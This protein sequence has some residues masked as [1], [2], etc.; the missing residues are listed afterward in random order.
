MFHSLRGIVTPVAPQRAV[1]STLYGIEWA[2]FC[3]TQ[4]IAHWRPHT[5]QQSGQQSGQQTGQQ[6]GQ[7]TVYTHLVIRDDRIQLYGYHSEQEREVFLH[8]IKVNGIGSAAA[9]N[10]LSTMSAPAVQQAIDQGD[11]IA[12]SKVPKIGTKSAQKIIVTLH[13]SIS[14]ATRADDSDDAVANAL[15][16]MGYEKGRVMRIVDELR[17]TL[18]EQDASSAAAYEDELF[19]QALQQLT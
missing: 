18:R 14:L 5:G 10:I 1:L 11:H 4:S 9:L 2:L 13:G 7:Q 17:G 12:F 3:S 16:A 15:I 6:S 8:L 19:K